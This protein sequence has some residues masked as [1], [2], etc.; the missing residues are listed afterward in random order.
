MP[1]LPYVCPLGDSPVLQEIFDCVARHLLTQ[2]EQSSEE[3]GSCFYRH[4]SKPLMCAIGC[5]IDDERYTVKIEQLSLDYL[6]YYSSGLFRFPVNK[7]ELQN[8]LWC[9]QA[10][11]DYNKP[12]EWKTE[13]QKV[14]KRFNLNDT[15]LV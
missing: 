15:V 11:H 10:L 8:L 1:T 14:A 4:P 13:L 3:N 2:K 12:S 6:I 9:L 7:A 5:L